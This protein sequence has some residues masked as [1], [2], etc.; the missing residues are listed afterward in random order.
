MIALMRKD[1]PLSSVD[2]ITLQELSFSTLIELKNDDF[3]NE[4]SREMLRKN[5]IH[6]SK[7]IQSDN[8]ETVPLTI[9]KYG[10]IHLTGESCKRQNASSICYKNVVGPYTNLAYG[11]MALK[12]NENPL[13]DLLMQEA[14]EYFHIGS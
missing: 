1:H 7:V 9:R 14:K 10:G 8:I 6:F 12:D 5:K 4:L 13:I 11:F 2:S 3:S